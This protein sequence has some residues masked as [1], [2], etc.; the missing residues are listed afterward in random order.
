V[1]VQA[2]VAAGARAA[3]PGADDPN[4]YTFHRFRQE[5]LDFNRRTL[6]E[7]YKKVGH[8]DP[9]WDDDAIQAL[10]LL[11]QFFA[12]GSVEPIYQKPG[13]PGP[14]DILKHVDGAV[15]A[16]CDDAIVVYARGA[17]LHERGDVQAAK[18]VLA[19]AL[20]LAK[21]SQYPP[22]RV[23]AIASRLSRLFD[24]NQNRAARTTAASLA[25]TALEFGEKSITRAVVANDH[26]H[27]LATLEET[28]E[29]APTD[30][31]QKF[32]AAIEAQKDADPWM[33]HLF[34][35]KLHVTQAWDARGDGPARTVRD[36][37]WQRFFEELTKA[38]EHL[39]K[40]HDLHPQYPEAASQMIVVAK[41][42]GSR[43]NETGRD[44]FDKAVKAQFDYYLAY[45]EYV[46]SIYPKWGG[47]YEQMV[48][49]GR[50]CART[51]RYDTYV[52]YQLVRICEKINDDG[53]RDLAIFKNPRV[54][55]HVSRMLEEFV[56]QGPK[57]LQHDW[58]RTYHLGI[59]WRAGQYRD[60]AALMQK[61]GDKLVP[62]ALEKV[63]GS[64]PLVT[65][66]VQAM[67]SKHAPALSRAE[68]AFADGKNYPAAIAAYADV[69]ADMDKENDQTGRLFVR[70]RL[71]QFQI[72]KDFYDGKEISLTPAEDFVP[73]YAETGDWKRGDD[74]TL[75]G[76][77]K[78]DGRN[79][80]I[81]CNADFGDRYE[82]TAK[83]HWGNPQTEL[84]ALFV[85]VL[86]PY[87]SYASIGRHG[88]VFLASGMDSKTLAHPVEDVNRLTVRVNGWQMSAKLNGQEV[89]GVRMRRWLIKEVR[90]GLGIPREVPGWAVRFSDVKIQMIGA[91]GDEN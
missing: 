45:D 6:V 84:A 44:W 74:G 41:G 56:Q 7:A 14:D 59:A 26:R 48:E 32:V 4:T 35:G 52:P 29:Q 83:V 22:F 25:R 55:P 90:I 62:A 76:S 8:R 34:K 71:R 49:F 73:W 17:M 23:G 85:G 19:E 81:L 1:L 30:V 24:P 38:R 64:A 69:L 15:A 60:A 27:V 2:A 42:A 80:R 39:A 28:F 54:Y 18:P 13:G 31:K 63:R 88:D 16:G 75:V 20:E 50:E 12:D 11:S 9:K 3:I 10:E 21:Q 33:L 53:A 46:E 86:Q 58:A 40:A 87:G 47:S 91:A 70:Y 79:A 68:T 51:R 5:R 77:T 78:G 65:S 57:H 72:E 61:L 36:E 66:E 43:L 67:T 82:L 89:G 37:G